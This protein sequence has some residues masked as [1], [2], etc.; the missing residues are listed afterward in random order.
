MEARKDDKGGEMGV[1]VLSRYYHVLPRYDLGT[2]YVY[3]VTY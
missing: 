2:S 3:I 1:F